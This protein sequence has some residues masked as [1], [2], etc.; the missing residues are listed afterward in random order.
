MSLGSVMLE[1]FF[2]D[3]DTN[4]VLLMEQSKGDYTVVMK[5]PSKFGKNKKTVYMLKP[6]SVA[7]TP[8]NVND[9]VRVEP[10]L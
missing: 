9:E 6:N 10:A 7:I 4:M 8:D 3:P 1:G 2:N 5:P